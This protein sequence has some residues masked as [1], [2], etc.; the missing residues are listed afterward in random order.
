MN[1]QSIVSRRCRKLKTIRDDNESLN[2]RL[3]AALDLLQEDRDVVWERY[4]WNI[5]R[6]LIK[7][8]NI[9][10]FDLAQLDRRIAELEMYPS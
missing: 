1:S 8:G 2:T 9:S 10:E 4:V 7:S 6:D 3:L 5:T